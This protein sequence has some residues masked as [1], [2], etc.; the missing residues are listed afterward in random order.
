MGEV[1]PARALG[2]DTL[3]GSRR[4]LG[5]DN[6]ITLSAAGALTLTL[7][8]LGEAE[9]ARTL[10]QD[11]LQRCRRVHG[12]DHATTLWAA[13]AL[14]VALVELGKVE[15]ARALGRTRCSAAAECSARATRSRS[16]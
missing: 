10:G 14:T 2:Q 9:P 1:E 11:T 12:P 16:T 5:F 4:I 8:Q 3:Q 6:P 7:N 13:A 15:A